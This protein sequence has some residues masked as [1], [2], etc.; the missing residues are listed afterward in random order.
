[1]SSL[2]LVQMA[3]CGLNVLTADESQ[4]ETDADVVW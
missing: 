1:M 2:L 4:E 3:A